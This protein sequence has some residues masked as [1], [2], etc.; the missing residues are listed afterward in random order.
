MGI[1]AL[2]DTK[3]AKS[4]VDLVH[5]PGNARTDKRCRL[6]GIIAKPAFRFESV[7]LPAAR[8]DRGR[9]VQ[10]AK[11]FIPC[12]LVLSAHMV[13]MH[14]SEQSSCHI[15][16][17]ERSGVHLRPAFERIIEIDR[18]RYFDLQRL[19]NA[20]PGVRGAILDESCRPLM[21]LRSC[22]PQTP[23]GERSYCLRPDLL[24]GRQ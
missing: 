21:S 5:D 10:R 15:C 7:F 19:E 8:I 13:S 1:C 9:I 11:E 18:R 23:D 22:Q 17:N 16:F 4:F 12:G 2:G 24:G 14:F 20:Q 3:S 6:T